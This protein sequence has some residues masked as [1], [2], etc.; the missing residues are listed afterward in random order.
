MT[1]H[2]AFQP[3]DL[4]TASDMNALPQFSTVV[5]PSDETVASSTTFQN[6]DHL[7]LAVPSNSMFIMEAMIFYTADGAADFKPGWLGP[8]SA[9]MQWVTNG[10]SITDTTNPTGANR[11][12]FAI[13][14][15]SFAGAPGMGA[16]VMA[17]MPRGLLVTAGTAGNLQ[18]RWAQATSNATATAVKAGSWIRLHKIA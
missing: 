6:D 14:E 8:A 2:S 17:F 18:L 16:I 13:T 4:L 5:K 10:G 9:T 12:V 3:G 1:F 11:L 7:V 15:A